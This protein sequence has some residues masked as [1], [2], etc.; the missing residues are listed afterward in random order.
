VGYGGILGRDRFQDVVR[1]PGYGW[2]CDRFQDVVWDLPGC[3]IFCSV[4]DLR[5]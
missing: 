4:A 5:T 1:G 3:G 2:P